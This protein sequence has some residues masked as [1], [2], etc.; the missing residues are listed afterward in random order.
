VAIGARSGGR[1]AP[2]EEDPPRAV[3]ER[4]VW[5]DH[6]YFASDR[7]V[8]LRSRRRSRGQ[9]ISKRGFGHSSASGAADTYHPSGVRANMSVM[10]R[11]TVGM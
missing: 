5:R 7:D 3:G 6:Q 10:K 11:V 8:G 9:S 1:Q 4:G 2:G